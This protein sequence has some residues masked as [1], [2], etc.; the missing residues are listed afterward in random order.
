M[1][2]VLELNHLNSIFSPSLTSTSFLCQSTA[3]SS[4]VDPLLYPCPNF[5]SYPKKWDLFSPASVFSFFDFS[6]CF[7]IEH[8]MCVRSHARQQG[9]SSEQTRPGIITVFSLFCA[10]S[11]GRTQNSHVPKLNSTQSSLGTG[12]VSNSRILQVSGQKRKECVV[13][14]MTKNTKASVIGC[15][16]GR[17]RRKC[18]ESNHYFCYLQCMSK[19]IKLGFLPWET[20][21]IDAKQEYWRTFRLRISKAK[22]WFDQFKEQYLLQTFV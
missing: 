16:G 22:N 10:S 8:F 18:W 13:D 9:Y 6:F 7:F 17:G 4:S 15:S 1:T 11:G 2:R 5:H 12:F 14:Y 19:R 21:N 20:I 3:P